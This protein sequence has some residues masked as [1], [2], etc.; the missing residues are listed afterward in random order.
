MSKQLPQITFEFSDSPKEEA[1]KEFLSGNAV[2]QT[3]PKKKS[4]RGRRS[5]KA[6]EAEV[7]QVEIPEDEILFS[8]QYWGI[9]EV[10]QMF[11]V[12]TS[13]I[14]SWENEFDILEPRKNRKGDRLFK[15]ADVKN[16]QLIHDLIRRRKYTVEGAKDYL[17][18]NKQAQELHAMVTSLQKIKS[19][20][21]EVKANL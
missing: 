20:L 12:N 3:P 11:K 1:P 13:L 7:D 2:P 6:L 10:A 4:T 19:F 14:R 8:K 5:L 9:R 15:P 16:L 17:K 21:L 18:R